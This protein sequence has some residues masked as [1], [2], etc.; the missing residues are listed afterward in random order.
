[1]LTSVWS[2]E[3]A[4]AIA[5]AQ[6]P[7]TKRIRVDDRLVEVPAPF[8]SS[9]LDWRDQPIY[10]ILVFETSEHLISLSP[11]GEL[12]PYR[13]VPDDGTQAPPDALETAEEGS[14]PPTTIA[15]S[16][17][18]LRRLGGLSRTR[19]RRLKGNRRSPTPAAWEPIPEG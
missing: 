9:P 3:I 18:I 6:S 10:Q 11:I 15:G 13:L 5:A 17:S 1:M 12:M 4:A 16:A 2:P 14:I 7:S 8:P 19:C